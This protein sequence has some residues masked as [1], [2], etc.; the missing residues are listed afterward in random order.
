MSTPI[1]ASHGQPDGSRA[2][3][4]AKEMG[5]ELIGAV[6]EGASSF[7][8]EQR[9]RAASEIASFGEMLRR[10]AQTLDEN[11]STVIGRYAEDAAG[12]ITQF[13]ERLRNRSLGMMAEDVEDFARQFPAAFIAAAVGVG[14]VAGRFL[15][16]SASR[17]RTPAMT[18]PAPR[19]MPSAHQPLGGARHD[20]GAVG[21]GVPSGNAGYG[22]TGTRE[23]H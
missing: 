23:S 11:R 16:S 4:D 1:G 5:T 21:G 15:I 17:S 20:Y 6:R 7:F 14:F 18:Q 8:E 19:P 12:E 13:A 9:D 3:E 10:S 22:G 2:V